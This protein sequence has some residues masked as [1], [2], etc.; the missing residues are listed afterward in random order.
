M[1][2]RFPVI[3]AASE[4]RRLRGGRADL[5]LRA[6]VI[7]LLLG[8]LLSLPAGQTF[9]SIPSPREEGDFKSGKVTLLESLPPEKRAVRLPKGREFP[10]H[11]KFGT[12]WQEPILC[13]P[14][15]LFVLLRLRGFNVAR[16]QV[17]RLIPI[18]KTGSS[19]A[20]L[21][22]AASALGL[23]H[24]VRKVSQSELFR[25]SPP[26]LVHEDIRS[27]DP[28]VRDS[29]HFFVTVRFNDQGQVGIIDGVSGNY[30]FIEKARFDRSFSGYVLV[31][32]MNFFGVPTQWA[33]GMIYVL[34]AV[35]AILSC[36]LAYLNRPVAVQSEAAAPC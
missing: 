15:A 27:T 3:R 14:N 35:V 2:A 19:L 25:L 12:S 26:F 29:G 11:L 22:K 20:D 8:L 24:Q 21:S 31:P 30:Q 36:A 32:E 23:K 9:A 18:T 13:G 10:E 17:T 33:W 28:E 4:P 1:Q 16:D 34:A 6:G 5:G 7:F